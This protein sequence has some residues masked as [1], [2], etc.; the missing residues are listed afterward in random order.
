MAVRSLRFS[1]Y[2][3][4]AAMLAALVTPA[5]AEEEAEQPTITEETIPGPAYQEGKRESNGDHE[6]KGE[7]S[8]ERGAHSVGQRGDGSGL[9]GSRRR[10]GGRRSD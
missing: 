1:K 5:I 10:E 7:R 4:A 8:S 9:D 3:V 2:A 6:A